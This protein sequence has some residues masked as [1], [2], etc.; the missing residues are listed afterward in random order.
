MSFRIT[1]I[2]HHYRRNNP[3]DDRQVDNG[4]QSLLQ[5][6]KA[7][8]I[9]H[10]LL[11]MA[12]VLCS[13]HT[14]SLRRCLIS[15]DRSLIE[16][17][18]PEIKRALQTNDT[19][20]NVTILSTLENLKSIQPVD[21]CCVTSRLL[22]FYRDRVFKDHQETSP[23]VMRQISSIANSF[24][25]MQKTLEQCQVHN[26]CHCSQE[27]TNATRTIHDNYDQLEAS[28]AALK[29]LGELDIFLAWIDENHQETSTA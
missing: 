19:F 20:P 18:F 10:W 21:V 9:S 12:L 17:S 3:K 25:Y 7:Q 11:G 28:S 23:E 8:N 22:T 5:D 26:Q 14:H 4:L 29:S 27:A 6:M 16:K 15:V 1:T 2:K 13:V 24:L